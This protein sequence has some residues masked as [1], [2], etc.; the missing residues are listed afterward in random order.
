MTQEVLGQQRKPSRKPH[1][2]NSSDVTYQYPEEVLY[3]PEDLFSKR[4]RQ[5]ELRHLATAL[6]RSLHKREG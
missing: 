1:S 4:D 2:F 6:H 5:V 3:L